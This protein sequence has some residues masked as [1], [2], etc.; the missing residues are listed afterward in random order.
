MKR[1]HEHTST[2][3]GLSEAQPVIGGNALIPYPNRES[4][5]LSIC[6]GVYYASVITLDL[7]SH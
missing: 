7:D 6:A 1:T 2:S 5:K 4:K 3:S